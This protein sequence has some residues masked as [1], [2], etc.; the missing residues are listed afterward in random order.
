ME[1]RNKY[2]KMMREQLNEWKKKTDILRTKIEKLRVPVKDDYCE[3]I[4][5][6]RRKV[7]DAELH[8]ET[9][10]TVDDDEWNECKA[11]TEETMCEVKESLDKLCYKLA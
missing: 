8:L 4:D 2:K 7:K 6:L 3:E 11:A 1:E 10:S 9:L 5:T